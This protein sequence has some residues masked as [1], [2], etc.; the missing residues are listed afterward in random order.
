MRDFT[1]DSHWEGRN[2]KN[3]Y[4]AKVIILISISTNYGPWLHLYYVGQMYSKVFMAKQ[5]ST[6]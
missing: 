5:E 3:E 1:P 6:N 4:L 2:N